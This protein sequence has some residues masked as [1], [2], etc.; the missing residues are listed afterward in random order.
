ME[1]VGQLAGGVAHD[2][3]NILTATLVQL[4]L[5]LER[6]TLAPD[7]R[8][9]LQELE[10]MAHRSAS[11][12]R[13][14][15]AFSRQ[16]VMQRAPINLNDVLGTLFTM[17]KRLLGE[18]IELELQF[19]PTA[20]NINA[21]VGMIEQLVTNLC[22]NARD[23]M[24]P[25][26]GRLTI[27]TGAVVIDELPPGACSEAYLGR[28]AFLSIADTGCGMEPATLA[29][30]FEPFFTTK[31][32]GKGTGLGLATVYGIA[33]Q[34]RG[35]V[36]VESEPGRGSLFRVMLPALADAIKAPLSPLAS[37]VKRGHE[38]ILLVE[39]EEPVRMMVAMALRRCGYQVHEAADGR[40]AVEQWGERAQEIDLLFSDIMMP[41]GMTGLDLVD[42]FKR[43]NPNLRVILSSGYSLELNKLN[44]VI[45]NGVDFLAK[46]F[47]IEKMADV[48]RKCLDNEPVRAP[49][50]G[51]SEIT[52]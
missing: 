41:N 17:L 42:Y 34:H 1:A 49:S 38:T 20:L 27:R 33:Q 4:G 10:R 48:V 5:M 52:G 46:P 50:A 24:L 26:G 47:T 7:L 30:A 37:P 39:D 14:L 18:N 45:G 32:V 51:L 40:Q 16:Q 29:H 9:G 25:R 2:Y 35:W 15:L 44:T 22:V 3:N 21:D 31:E 12:T 28:F 19:A 11:L 23:A 13:Q 8:A 43:G 6:T 36:E